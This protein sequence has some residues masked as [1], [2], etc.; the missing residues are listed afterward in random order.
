MKICSSCKIEKPLSAYHKRNGRPLGVMS[1][2]KECRS[3]IEAGRYVENKEFII[4][5]VRKYNDENREMINARQRI[6]HSKNKEVGKNYVA[7]NREK[8]NKY[9]RDRRKENPLL[10][11]QQNI[12]RRTLYAFTI[13]GYK[14]KQQTVE[15]LGADW[16]VVK[17]HIEDQ[18]KEG[19]SWK[20]RGDWEIDHIIPYASAKTEE[21]VI[22]LSHYKNLQPLW[23]NENR[24]KSG[25]Y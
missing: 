9:E 2:C 15:L 12:R 7:E 24:V 23:K 19:M 20:N 13:M 11:M 21:D 14:K 4:E 10:N 1:S 17:K 18:F 5:R 3:A 22:R 25:N 6:Y 16:P 8:I